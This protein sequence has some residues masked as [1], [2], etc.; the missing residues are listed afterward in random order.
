MKKSELKQIIREEIKKIQLTESKKLDKMIKKVFKDH[1]FKSKYFDQ[2]KK[3]CLE[4]FEDFDIDEITSE[5]IIEIIDASP[6]ADKIQK[7]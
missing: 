5:D 1:N 7:R 2:V 4:D 6:Y 3:D